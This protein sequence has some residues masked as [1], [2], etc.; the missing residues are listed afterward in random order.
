[1]KPG[2]ENVPQIDLF[3]A[4]KNRNYMQILWGIKIQ[5]QIL[6][7]KKYTVIQITVTYTKSHYIQLVTQ[8]CLAFRTIK[9]LKMQLACDQSE[10]VRVHQ[11]ETWIYIRMYSIIHQYNFKWN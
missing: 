4:K 2:E 3:W 9:T 6:S 1:M 5:V 8:L 7:T 11:N 10:M